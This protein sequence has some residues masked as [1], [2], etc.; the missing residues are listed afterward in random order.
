MQVE[1]IDTFNA[2]I[3]ENKYVMIDFYAEWCKSCKIFEPEF[4]EL[5]KIYEPK[6]KFIKIDIDILDDLMITYN[7]QKLPTFILLKDNQR[8][9]DEIIGPNS[10]LIKKILVDNVMKDSLEI[11]DDDF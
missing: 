7:I 5:I 6:C 3:S 10:N 2:I 4:N 8:I 11:K 1:N 9:G